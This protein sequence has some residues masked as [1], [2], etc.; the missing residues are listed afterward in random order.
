MR[1]KVLFVLGAAAT[2]SAQLVDDFQ[3]PDEFLGFYPHLISCDKYWH[4]KEG[5]AEL[6][7]CGNGLGFMDTDDTFTL[8]QCAEL[9]LVECGERTEIE[10]PISTTNCPRLYG[11]FADPE[12]CGVFYKCQDGKSNRYNC[13]P[14]LAYDQVSRGCRWADQV[15]E[16]SASIVT[17]DDEGGEFQCPRKSS[18]GTFT[19]H[20]HPADCRQYF[21]CIGGVPREYGCPLGT[22]FNTGSGSGVDGKCSDPESVPECKDYYGDLKFKS[23]DLS[24][25]GFD[26]G[27]LNTGTERVRSGADRFRNTNSIPRAPTKVKTTSSSREPQREKSRPAPPSLQAIVDTND[28]RDSPRV[29]LNRGRPSRPQSPGRVQSQR[30]QRPEPVQFRPE[31]IQ[32]EE[33]AF[34]QPTL[35]PRLEQIRIE[36]VAPTTTPEPQTTQVRT[37]RPSRIQVLTEKP[38]SRTTFPRRPETTTT[39]EPSTQSTGSRFSS[40]NRP[41][42]GSVFNTGGSTRFQP[43]QAPTT[44]TPPPPPP[45]TAAPVAASSDSEDTDEGLPDPVKAAPGPNGEE[46]YYYYYYYDDEEGGEEGSPKKV[47]S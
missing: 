42:F 2:V 41:G 32:E 33:T 19:K 26:T 36:S 12:D 9:H 46:Y 37:Q 10:P 13:P 6:K 38:T 8:E 17:V 22:V 18:A 1:S 3:C 15:K 35:P 23:G 25:N 16:C 24:K 34:I 4:C 31:P 11:T 29:S 40:A 21:L 5:I 43:T 14:G 20:A 44:T 47:Q 45:T 28:S 27:R 39:D 7:T 30:P